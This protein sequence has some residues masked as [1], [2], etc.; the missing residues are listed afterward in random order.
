MCILEWY[1]KKK[2]KIS[3]PIYEWLIMSFK[4]KM[5]SLITFKCQ[6]YNLKTTVLAC[7]K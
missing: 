3:G 6:A 4:T 1:F 5:T 2:V 7:T